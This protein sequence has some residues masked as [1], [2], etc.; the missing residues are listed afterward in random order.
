MTKNSIDNLLFPSDR[1]VRRL[2]QDAKS[3][4]KT[5]NIPLHEALNRVAASNGMKCGWSEAI[6]QLKAGSSKIQPAIV[7][8]DTSPLAYELG[9][10]DA[11]LDMLEWE[12][13]TNQSKDGLIYNYILTFYDN[14]PKE[15]LK[16]IPDLSS[17]NMVN[18]SVNAFDVEPEPDWNHEQTLSTKTNT[19]MNAYRKL[20]VLGLNKLMD[21]NLLSLDWDGQTKVKDGHIEVNL[22][23][24]NAIVSWSDAGF[25][26]VRISVWWKYNHDLHPQANMEGNHRES[27]NTA[28]PLA[29]RSHYRKFVGVVCCAWLERDK[30]KYLQGIGNNHIFEKY[31]RKGELA[32]LKNMP[33]PIPQGFIVEGPF[34]L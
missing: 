4:V 10:T 5:E 28:A 23:G 31:T 24:H 16:K 15:I 7:L 11:E 26:E 27:F 19:D 29:K 6:S 17:G 22:A 13:D 3:M 34:H 20:L 1:N 8:K 21:R 2:K 25:G 9:L 12:V 32:E 33:N 30:G 18:V 14:C